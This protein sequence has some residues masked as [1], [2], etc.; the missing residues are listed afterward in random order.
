M[1]LGGLISKKNRLK[2]KGKFDIG[3]K[4]EVKV[5][6]NQTVDIFVR[7]KGQPAGNFALKVYNISINSSS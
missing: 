4:K 5:L 2:T 1:R 6:D 7:S 3:A